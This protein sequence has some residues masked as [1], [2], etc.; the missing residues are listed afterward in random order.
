MSLY[1]YSTPQKPK[2]ILNPQDYYSAPEVVEQQPHPPQYYAP[3]EYPADKK[4]IT[5]DGHP[6]GRGFSNEAPLPAK[7][8]PKILG[9]RKKI[10]IIV[11]IAIAAFIILAVALGAGLGAGLKKEKEIIQHPFCKEKPQYCT[12]SYLNAEY[13]SKKGAFNGSGIALAGESW[14][15]GERRIFT[16]YFQHHTGDIRYMQYGTNQLWVGGTKTHTVATDAKNGTAI[17]A[18]AYTLNQ[19]GWV[20][21][22][23]FAR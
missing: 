23:I 1:T 22:S 11:V 4:L 17:S 14:N 5:P 6:Y 7:P 16:L 8:E 2:P 3:V 13:T 19:T 20:S 12:G 18:V 10:F 15:A 21:A 9:M